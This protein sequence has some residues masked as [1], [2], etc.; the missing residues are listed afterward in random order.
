V[1]LINLRS[2]HVMSMQSRS[3]QRR[4]GAG[5]H[6]NS[7]AAIATNDNS[8]TAAAQIGTVAAATAVPTAPPPST[9]P[10]KGG[11]TPIAPELAEAEVRGLLVNILG[12]DWD[13]T[14]EDTV[15]AGDLGLPL[16]AFGGGS[17][18]ANQA[19]LTATNCNGGT[20]SATAAIAPTSMPTA[21]LNGSKGESKRSGRKK[22]T[23]VSAAGTSASATVP[24]TM[25]CSIAVGT[26][27]ASV[28]H[29]LI[30][31]PQLLSEALSRQC[32]QGE[33]DEVDAGVRDEEEPAPLGGFSLT[34][35]RRLGTHTS[36]SSGPNLD[37]DEARMSSTNASEEVP[38]WGSYFPGQHLLQSRMPWTFHE[39]MEHIAIERR[40]AYDVPG[41]LGSGHWAPST[42]SVR[43]RAY[44]ASGSRARTFNEACCNEYSTPIPTPSG[45]FI[46][47]P[48]WTSVDS[49]EFGGIAA[50][51]LLDD[52]LY[53][54]PCE[55]GPRWVGES[56]YEEGIPDRIGPCGDLRALELARPCLMAVQPRR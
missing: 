10:S 32:G 40:R 49:G 53:V 18:V 43:A 41:G 5:K 30:E 46:R 27:P 15:P 24:A 21:G 35:S 51:D 38:R 31:P 3:K 37:G 11:G 22:K 45:T 8:G 9:V 39:S 16:D 42:S 7:V 23:Q 26:A 56:P 34:L 48:T 55:L 29:R 12:P 14:A 33:E 20:P 4:A 1:D 19:G 44:V 54:Q 2:L 52:P 13:I 6:K 28:Q 47:T 25:P 50:R 17:A 36:S